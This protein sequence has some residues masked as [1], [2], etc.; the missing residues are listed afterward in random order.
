LPD[1]AAL[2]EIAREL[3]SVQAPVQLET[4]GLYVDVGK[5]IL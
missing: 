2:G 1:F 5:E 3:D 4:A